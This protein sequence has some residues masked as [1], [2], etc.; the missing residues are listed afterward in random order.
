VFCLKRLRCSRKLLRGVWEYY[1][2]NI[3]NIKSS[4]WRIC[5][6]NGSPKINLLNL[7][8]RLQRNLNY[9]QSSQRYRKSRG[10]IARK[11]IRVLEVCFTRMWGWRLIAHFVWRWFQYYFDRAIF[12]FTYITPS[13]TWS[14]DRPSL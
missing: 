2:L 8:F 13:L 12:F 11:L 9:M 5:L 6:N 10:N 3:Y 1:V 7:D 14:W 4:T